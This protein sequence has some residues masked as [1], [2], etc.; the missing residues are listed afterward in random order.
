[1]TTAVRHSAVGVDIGCGLIAQRTNLRAE[2]LPDDLG[3][4]R[5]AIEAA[6]PHGRTDNGGANDRGAWGSMPDDVAEVAAG[7]RDG[8]EAVRASAGS[9]L[10]TWWSDERAFRHLGTLGTGNHFC[11]VCL[12]EDG[13][14]WLMLH[15]GSRGIG[16]AIG[17]TFIDR[18]KKVAE[19]YFIPLPDSDLAYFPEGTRDFDEYVGAVGSAQAAGGRNRTCDFAGKRA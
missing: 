12:D 2:D 13:A 9:R 7:L 18:A 6:I 3:G 10:A 17:T 1:M 5:A 8:L 19:R 16:N 14:V 11:E 4:V 15:S